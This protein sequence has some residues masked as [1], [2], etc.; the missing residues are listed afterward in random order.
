M[1]YPNQADMPT[2]AAAQAFWHAEL[3][4]PVMKENEN[5]TLDYSLESLQNVDHLLKKFHEDGITVARI[6]KIVFQIGC[7]LGQVVVNACPGSRWMHP[8]DIDPSLPMSD[9]VVQH[10]P[11]IVWAPMTTA[12]KVLEDPANNSLLASGVDAVRI[13]GATKRA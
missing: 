7:Y 8:K 5:I 4:V 1:K 12:V 6:P 9:L 11:N 2:T 13:Y 3:F 10:P